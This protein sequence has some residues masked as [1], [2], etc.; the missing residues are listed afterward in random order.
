MELNQFVS[1]LTAMM[2]S[3]QPLRSLANLNVK[4]QEGFAAAVRIFALLDTAPKVKEIENA[5]ILTV[6]KASINFQNVSFEYSDGTRA[7][8]NVK[9]DALP[10]TVNALVGPSGSGK[11]TIMNLI[12][13]FYDPAKLRV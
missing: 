10:G 12:P 3:Y 2:L 1:F 9:L 13:R 7:L 6:K 5:E 8:K 11:S 4:L